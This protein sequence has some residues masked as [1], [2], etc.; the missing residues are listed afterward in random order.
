MSTDRQKSF[1]AELSTNFGHLHFPRLTHNKQ[2]ASRIYNGL[3]TSPARDISN[4][5]FTQ[6]KTPHITLRFYFRCTRNH[7]HI[8]IRTPGDYYGKIL[9]M[10]EDYIIS[11]VGDEDAINFNL[12]DKNY[13]VITL[14]DI[15]SNKISLHIQTTHDRWLT[16]NGAYRTDEGIGVSASGG[17]LLTFHLNIIERNASFI[18]NPDEV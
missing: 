1:I 18:D 4:Y 8:Y 7:Y 10:N 14:D 15:P 17:I 3:Y 2:V 5:L 13:K 9:G 12:L 11:A 16:S 6:R